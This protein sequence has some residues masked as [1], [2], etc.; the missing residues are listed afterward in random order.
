MAT[1]SYLT[2]VFWAIAIVGF[3]FVL[4]RRLKA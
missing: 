3:S 1:V 4:W 2:L